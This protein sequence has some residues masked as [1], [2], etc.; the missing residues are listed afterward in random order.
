[1][2][3]KSHWENIQGEAKEYDALI[4]KLI[5]YYHEQNDL[6]I[7]LIP[8]KTDSELKV[9]DLGGGTG[10]LALLILRTFLNSKVTVF[11]VAEK[12]LDICK[13]KLASY[14]DKTDFIQ[15]D[16][17]V[18]NLGGGYDL[19]ISSLAIHHLEDDRK[20][21]T[22]NMIYISLEPGGTFL[23]RDIVLGAT[24]ALTKEYEALWKRFIN[25][26]GEDPDIW[27]DRY[28][29]EDIPASVEDQI[30]WLK[31]TGFDEVGCH[32]RHLNFAIFGGRKVKA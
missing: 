7:S 32:W 27:F 24:P 4:P 18:E 11:D 9:L 3:N 20:K 5:P 30:G 26:N 8:F 12:M 16:F 21:D 17:T 22:Y 10:N 1:M 19:I 29:N 28:L 6:I 13:V 25:S 14:N 31:K 2:G 15:G 23:N